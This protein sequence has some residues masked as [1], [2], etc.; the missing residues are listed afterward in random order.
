MG[1]NCC[2]GRERFLLKRNIWVSHY[3]NSILLYSN[4]IQIFMPN[5]QA[6][7]TVTT[8]E[9]RKAVELL[10]EYT[11]LGRCEPRAGGNSALNKSMFVGFFVCRL[12]GKAKQLLDA[13]VT[14][15]VYDSSPIRLRL[16]SVYSV[17]Q[18]RWRTTDREERIL[19]RRGSSCPR[20]QLLPLRHDEC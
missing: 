20:P 2:L 8:E 1:R 7:N 10:P 14:L 4:G 15:P 5:L 11:Q 6:A 19:P 3:N 16:D 17:L 18:H 13:A 9:K 12:N